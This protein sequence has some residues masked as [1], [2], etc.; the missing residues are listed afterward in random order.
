MCQWPMALLRDD[1][2]D[3]TACSIAAADSLAVSIQA[4]SAVGVR[5]FFGPV[6]LALGFANEHQEQAEGI[7]EYK[8]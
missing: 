7:W 1:T 4:K 5:N 2:I 8:T 6:G 3:S